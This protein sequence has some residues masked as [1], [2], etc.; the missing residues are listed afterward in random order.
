MTTKNSQQTRHFCIFDYF[1]D[2]AFLRWE[3]VTGNCPVL[4]PGQEWVIS[5]DDGT[6]ISTK[7]IETEVVSENEHRIFLRSC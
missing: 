5:L 2:G 1:L 4:V 7:V 6:Q 3:E